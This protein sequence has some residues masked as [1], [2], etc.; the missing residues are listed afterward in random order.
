MRGLNTKVDEFFAAV[1]E[2]DFSFIALCETWLG[3]GVAN[4]ELFPSDYQVFRRDRKYDVVNRCSG[5]GF[6]WQ[7][8]I[9]L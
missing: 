4:S 3:D 7:C 2:V 8:R 1:A 5:G 9:L 6:C